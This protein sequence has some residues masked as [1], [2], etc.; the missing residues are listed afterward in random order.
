[1]SFS[2]FSETVLPRALFHWTKNQ[3]SQDQIQTETLTFSCSQQISYKILLCQKIF[4]KQVNRQTHH[5]TSVF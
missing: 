3:N 1:M 4:L 5:Q 2:K